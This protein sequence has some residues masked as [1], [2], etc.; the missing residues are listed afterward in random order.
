MLKKESEQEK[1]GAPG[2]AGRPPEAARGAKKPLKNHW[3]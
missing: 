3:F 1:I 2:A